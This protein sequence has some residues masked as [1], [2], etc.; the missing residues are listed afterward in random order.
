MADLVTNG[1]DGIPRRLVDAGDG[2][3]AELQSMAAEA[4][5]PTDLITRGQDGIPR[6]MFDNGDGTWS[7]VVE[8]VG[9]SAAGDIDGGSA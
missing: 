6:R 4:M 5:G 8:V 2:T 3:W 9:V 1:R 7:E